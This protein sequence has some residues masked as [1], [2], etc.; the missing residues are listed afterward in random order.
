VPGG[1]VRTEFRGIVASRRQLRRPRPKGAKPSDLAIEQPAKF[2][3]ELN[4][5]TAKARGITIQQSLM[6]GA[7]ELIQ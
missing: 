1:F 4:L 2:E 5:K 3:L 7:N 6:L